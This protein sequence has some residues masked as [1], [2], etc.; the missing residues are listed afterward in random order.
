MRIA[1]FTHYTELYGANRSLL[2]LLDGLKP[3]GVEPLVIAPCRGAVTHALDERGVP[4][5]VVPS[6]W[7]CSE[8]PAA[9]RGPGQL[10]ARYRSRRDA[11]ARMRA[12]LVAAFRLKR[13]LQRW[14]V[15]LLYTN[16]SVIPLGALVA[17]ML[18]KPHVWHL[19]E[20]GDLD[21]NLAPDWGRT[22]FNSLIAR[23]DA[24]IC[25]S[26]AIA[27][28]YHEA[29]RNGKWHVVYNGVAPMGQIDH[30]RER[31]DPYAD[32]CTPFV[33]SIIGLVHPKKGQEV[34][35]RA[36]AVVKRSHPKVRLL[37]AGADDRGG[38]EVARLRRLTAELGVEGE[39]SFIG[40]VEDPYVVYTQSH[41]VLMCSE[42]EGMGRVTVEAMTASRPLVGYDHGGTKELVLHEVN[43]LL[44]TGGAPELATCMLRLAQAPEQARRMGEK[45]WHLSREKY[46]IESYASRI[47]AI[48][49]GV[50]GRQP[51]GDEEP[52]ERAGGMP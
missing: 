26:Q 32:T 10:L 45:G 52:S 40:Y 12:N 13:D 14:G 17:T 9:G 41:A 24:Q 35:I 39:V 1:F 36:L 29:L 3:Y 48:C 47:H 44:Y 11:V 25:V 43:G 28:H 34:A 6:A 27:S 42:N 19:R 18:N 2:N 51:G 16:S 23:A 33:F 37:I 4:C 15:E 8:P 50:L 49:C 7:W 21:Y 30:L 38:A 22:L 20:F 5:L 46:C 31:S